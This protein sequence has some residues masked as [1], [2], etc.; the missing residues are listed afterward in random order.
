MITTCDDQ[1]VAVLHPAL[2]HRKITTSGRST[3]PRGRPA[4][5][6]GSCS[7]G[8]IRARTPLVDATRGQVVSAHGHDI[9][10]HD[11]VI[12]QLVW[13]LPLH[14]Q[15]GHHHEP[16]STQQSGSQAGPHGERQ[17]TP[18]TS[19]HRCKIMQQMLNPG[20]GSTRH[21]TRILL[22]QQPVHR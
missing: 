10:G 8:K 15:K 11:V 18:A 21:F 16:H 7:R 19:G 22:V 13:V 20:S 6:G 2:L 4:R 3:G 12:S 14:H 1:T 9:A 17:P 5:L